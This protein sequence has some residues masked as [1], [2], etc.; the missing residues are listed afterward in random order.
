MKHCRNGAA[1]PTSTS[2]RLECSGAYPDLCSQGR[3]GGT[4]SSLW[5]G[6]LTHFPPSSIW[7]G[8]LKPRRLAYKRR[9]VESGEQGHIV[10]GDGG[11]NS[12][13]I[14]ITRLLGDLEDFNVWF[15]LVHWARK[16]RCSLCVILRRVGGLG[17]HPG[18]TIRTQLEI[19]TDRS[20]VYYFFHAN[21]LALT[22]NE[23]RY[24]RIHYGFVQ[25]TLRFRQC[26]LYVSCQ[27]LGFSLCLCRV[28]KW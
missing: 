18:L 5:W 24:I 25:L 15:G 13:E 7:C 3:A 19:R 21:L 8:R 28:Y 6:E 1:F 20:S 23:K 22:L 11:R 16:H 26:F 4:S 14:G 12:A 2:T 27:R 17:S 9:L 10:R